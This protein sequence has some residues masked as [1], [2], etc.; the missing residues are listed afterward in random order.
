[1][2]KQFLFFTLLLAC[3]V[4][5]G[6]GCGD[7]PHAKF[8]SACF[9]VIMN[10]ASYEGDMAADLQKAA[11]GSESWPAPLKAKADAVIAQAKLFQDMKKKNI[12][13]HPF[14]N[15]AGEMGKAAGS[16]IDES[17]KHE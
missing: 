9:K 8:K 4:C 5:M 7:P 16:F 2:K 10:I 14:I 17:K 3:A 13:G 11:E 6:S 15:A 1:M 12:G